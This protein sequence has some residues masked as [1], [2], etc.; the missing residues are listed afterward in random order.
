MSSRKPAARRGTTFERSKALVHNR[1]V[2]VS[3]LETDPEQNKDII[4]WKQMVYERFLL[5]AGGLTRT[6][7][8]PLQT[9]DAEAGTIKGKWLAS[10]T[11]TKE[12]ARHRQTPI[13]DVI[14]VCTVRYLIAN[15]ERVSQQLERELEQFIKARTICEGDSLR[16]WLAPLER[17][18]C[19]WRNWQVGEV[20]LADPRG[21]HR[22]WLIRLRE[23]DRYTWP[24]QSPPTCT[25]EID[26]L[27]RIVIG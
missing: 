9:G 1:R 25:D 5:E 8:T 24:S 21:I 15:I 6:F 3:W 11:N 17:A 10:L 4:R 22:D 2:Y 14:G 7:D 20:S 12:A 19:S 23:H 16:V 26:D 27:A 13:T 18:S